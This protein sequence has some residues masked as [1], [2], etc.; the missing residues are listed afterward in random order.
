[1]SKKP[2][3]IKGLDNLQ[4]FSFSIEKVLWPGEDVHLKH[5]V[6]GTE[7]I[8]ENTLSLPLFF[9]HAIQQRAALNCL[10]QTF[11]TRKLFE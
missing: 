5:V 7:N 4:R 11:L 1:M 9:Y 8:L 10:D 2:Q 3:N 6:L